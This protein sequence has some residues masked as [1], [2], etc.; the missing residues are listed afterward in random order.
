[1][2]ATILCA[3]I[4]LT[5]P[6]GA[7][8]QGGLPASLSANWYDTVG[9]WLDLGADQPRAAIIFDTDEKLLSVDWEFEIPGSE[10][11]FPVGF[12]STERRN[13]S[14]ALSYQPTAVCQESGTGPTF[15]VAGWIDRLSMAIVERWTVVDAVV[16]STIKPDGTIAATL[17]LSYRKE[18]VLA[19]TTT[20]PIRCIAYHFTSGQIWALE[21][22][23]PHK[24]LAIDPT[25]S[26]VTVVTDG[27]HYPELANMRS[28]QV[29]YINPAAP[30]GG[31]FFVHL[32]PEPDWAFIDSEEQDPQSHVFFTRDVD[33]DG[34]VDVMDVRTLE[35]ARSAMDSAFY[36]ANFH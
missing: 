34:N 8:A 14:I 27:S 9:C 32:R 11:Q 21:E 24:L 36:N 3:V 31:G 26:G 5:S 7:H 23:A 25:S 15:Y 12:T 16:A 17:N 29:T 4:L 13:D 19:S 1:M 22:L 20:G 10:A 33:F 18:V 6:Q 30:D 28:A 2:H 35:S